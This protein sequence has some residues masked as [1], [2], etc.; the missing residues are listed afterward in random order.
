[1][2]RE[3]LTGQIVLVADAATDP[4]V[5]HPQ[6]VR[7]EGIAT[8]LC[9][10]L[11][12]KRGAMGVLR[13]YG[14]EGHRF[15]RE[16][17]V[18]LAAVGAHGAVAIENAEAYDVLKRLDRDKSRFVRMVTHEL[19]SPLQVS[20][21]L[22]A[23]LRGGYTG[24]LNDRQLD[25]VDRARHRL[26]FLET[27]VDDLLDLAAGRTDV[28]ADKAEPGLVNL[29]A[30]LER[31]CAS[32]DAAA[33]ARG[34]SLELSCADPAIAVWSDE[35]AIGRVADNLVGNAV[36]YTRSGG[37]RVELAREGET[38]RLVVADTGIGIPAHEQP[39][40]FE[41]FFRAGNAKAVEEHG[42][43][44]GLA[45]VRDLVSRAGGRVSIDSAEGRGT[46]VT[47]TLPLARVPAP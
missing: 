40:L 14:G 31:V 7:A 33:R 35:W 44:L 42:T 5:Y 30:V 26:S 34:L 11:L 9:A 20:E 46:T 21:N 4:R 36:K 47:V 32:F 16:D 29:A 19:R 1:V 41:E 10:P 15:S 38:A 43:G 28:R 23:V 37:V 27:L 13:A 17:G 12:G 22:L 25:L 3:V 39:R 18:F 6:E 8:M 2:D 24:P 45:I